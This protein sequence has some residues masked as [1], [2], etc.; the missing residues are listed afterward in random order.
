LSIHTGDSAPNWIKIQYSTRPNTRSLH[1][2]YGRVLL[3]IIVQ[4][5]YILPV[6]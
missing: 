3:N 2:R 6:N 5:A 1:W 4:L